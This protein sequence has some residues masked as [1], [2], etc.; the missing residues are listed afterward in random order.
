M[1]RGKRKEPEPAL[2]PGPPGAKIGT[3]LLDLHDAIRNAQKCRQTLHALGISRKEWMEIVQD[4]DQDL[5]F[6]ARPQLL[7][8]IV[9]LLE[10]AGKPLGREALVR[11]LLVQGGS[12]RQ[13]RDCLHG[14]LRSGSLTLYRGDKIGLPEWSTKSQ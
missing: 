5:R 8:A 11:A 9:A 14:Y 2:R 4:V 12:S 6:L 1:V 3:V 10:K 7:D 13:V